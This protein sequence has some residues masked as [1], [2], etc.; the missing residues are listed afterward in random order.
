MLS[1]LSCTPEIFEIVMEGK[2]RA[3]N[4]MQRD[5]WKKRTFPACNTTTTSKSYIA[6]PPRLA[7]AWVFFWQV[8]PPKWP[9]LFAGSI[10]SRVREPEKHEFQAHRLVPLLMNKFTGQYKNTQRESVY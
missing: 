2:D 6:K 10:W 3:P 1:T 4:M 9:K 5:L 7:G 8:D